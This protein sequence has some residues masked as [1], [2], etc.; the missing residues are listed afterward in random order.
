V[1]ALNLVPVG[2]LDGGHVV[3]SGLRRA[4]KPLGGL[5]FVALLFFAFFW[6]GWLLW[7][8]VLY[9]V[10]RRRPAPLD[11]VTPLGRGRTW[12]AVGALVLFLLCLTPVPMPG[13]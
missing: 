11:D 6:P 5:I 12:G 9:F 13:F 2:Q 1:T 4:Y 3:F 10:S 7:V 8:G